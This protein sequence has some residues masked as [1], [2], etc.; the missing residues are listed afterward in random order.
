MRLGAASFAPGGMT[1]SSGKVNGFLAFLCVAALLQGQ[2]GP[3]SVIT[4][5]EYYKD[6]PSPVSLS[7][8]D[9]RKKLSM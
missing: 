2:N 5:L 6:S 3:R 8:A 1:V 9:F 7:L 4:S